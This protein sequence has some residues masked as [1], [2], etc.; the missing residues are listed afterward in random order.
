MIRPSKERKIEIV[1]L[2][3]ARNAVFGSKSAYILTYFVRPLKA[4]LA[5]R[6]IIAPSFPPSFL[7]ETGRAASG[8]KSRGEEQRSREQRLSNLLR[9]VPRRVLLSS[10]CLFCEALFKSAIIALMQEVSHGVLHAAARINTKYYLLPRRAH[11]LSHI[12]SPEH[13]KFFLT[14]NGFRSPE[15]VSDFAM[16]AGAQPRC[17]KKSGGRDCRRLRCLWLEEDFRATSTSR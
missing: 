1:G 12:N 5:P 17:P 14:S 9:N 4:N 7:S 11:V 15:L 3:A 2:I 10:H 16:L 13:M 6:V 8:G